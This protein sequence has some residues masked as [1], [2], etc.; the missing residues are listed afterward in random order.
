MRRRPALLLLSI[1]GCFPAAARADGGA[2]ADFQPDPRAVQ[3]SGP[4]YRYPQDGWIVLHIEGEPYDRGVQHGRLLAPEI[5]AH[6]RCFAAWQGSKDSAAAWKQ[7][8]TL[9]NALFLRRYDKEYLEEMKGIADGASAAGAKFDGRPLD[10][11][12]VVAL[13]A[14]PEVM[15]LDRA[16]DATPTGLEGQRFPLDGVT[17]K[18]LP[19]PE[20]CSAF[21]ATG[22]ATKDGKVVFGHITMFSLYPANFYNVWLD[23]KPAKGHRVFMQTYPAGIQSGMDYY[24]NDAGLLCCETT[25]SQTRFDITGTALASRIRQALQYADTIDRAAE[26]LKEGNNGLYTNEWLL[27]D[28]KTNEIA[29]LELGTHKTRLSRSSKGEWFG[30]TEGFYWGCNNTKDLEVRL[31]TLATTDGRPASTVWRPSDRDKKWLELYDRYKGK[32]DEG[33]GKVAFTTPPIAAYRSVDAKFTTTDLAKQLKTWALF[34]PPLTRTW[35]PTFDERQRFP[36]VQPLVSNPWTVLHAAAPA[37]QKDRGP[38]AL[39]LHN[40]EDGRR[41][42]DP[43]PDREEAAGRGGRRSGEAQGPPA[44]HG[45]LLP[46]SDADTWLVTAFAN[47]ERIVSMENG[48]R[49]RG[50]GKVSPEDRDRL[51]VALFE[52]RSEY[53]L[54]RRAHPEVPLLKTRA[55]V[56]QSDWHRVASGKGV[57]LLHTL[58][59]EL[60]AEKFAALMEEFGKRHA[61]Q[62]VSTEE[63]RAFIEKA[64]DRKLD[65]FFDH[66]LQETGLP[67]PKAGVASS[68]AVTGLD[69]GPFSVLTFLSELEQTLIVYGTQAEEPTNRQAAEELQKAIV[70]RGPNVTVPVKSDR[71][72]TEDELK[73]HHVLLVGRPDTNS[74]V[75]RIRTAL[76]VTFGR[77]SFAV[78][79]ETYAHANS[80]VIAAAE[81]PLRGRYSIVVAAGLSAAATLRTAPLLARG[82]PGAE[83]V[84]CPAGAAL[85][86][87]IVPAP[88]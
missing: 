16:L 30:G 63:F 2:P 9:V 10:L 74:V 35:Q 20:R 67:R 60:G 59:G 8:R 71:A 14:W 37:P 69:G 66:W 18:P 50:D 33:F 82:A 28:V 75:A 27:A 57:L 1:L 32:I 85:R 3:R 4:A 54:G 40:P 13:N 46:R 41:R 76:P 22:P 77:Q 43:R 31:E 34:G 25:I 45:T 72:V 26:I 70:E 68:E 38:I 61:G 78:R 44:W 48:M 64:T 88:R 56:R 11:L 7:T 42:L 51:A 6:V 36:E 79:G 86:G 19:K 12:D 21:A 15:T 55:D 23:V 53:E 65:E 80:G 29:M 58:R 49:R 5:A 81:N 84:V 83:V 52:Q 87:L 39:D 73:N 62:R 17:P 24:Y 47:Y